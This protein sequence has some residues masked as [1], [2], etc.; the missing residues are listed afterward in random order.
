VLSGRLGWEKDQTSSSLWQLNCK[1]VLSI[2]RNHVQF[3]KTRNWIA[4]EFLIPSE[5][6]V[7]NIY[8]FYFTVRSLMVRLTAKRKIFRSAFRMEKM[9]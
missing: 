7:S 3:P 4:V 5:N 1:F 6:C 2:G 8:S 9:K